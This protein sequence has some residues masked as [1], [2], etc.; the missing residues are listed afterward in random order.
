M[1]DIVEGMY[2]TPHACNSEIAGGRVARLEAKI[3]KVPRPHS[4]KRQI[5]SKYRVLCLSWIERPHLQE[6]TSSFESGI[7]FGQIR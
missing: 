5:K 4:S 7:S 2:D 3:G 6:M 1:L